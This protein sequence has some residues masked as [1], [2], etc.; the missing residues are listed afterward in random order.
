MSY[1]ALGYFHIEMLIIYDKEQAQPTAIIS[2]LRSKLDK[3]KG[4]VHY[5]SKDEEINTSVIYHK[6]RN[7]VL[8][9]MYGHEFKNNEEV[10]K[11]FITRA[12][13]LAKKDD[14]EGV[15]RKKKFGIIKG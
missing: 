13:Y 5:N 7:N 12:S 4:T 1:Q 15:I 3:L 2:K 6:P 11:D 9:S 14:Q 10:Y 8:A